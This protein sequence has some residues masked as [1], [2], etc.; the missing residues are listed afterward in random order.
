MSDPSNP[1]V[2]KRRRR[3]GSN[4]LGIT[5]EVADAAEE[6]RGSAK[7]TYKAFGLRRVNLAKQLELVATK[8]GVKLNDTT[9]Q[10]CARYSVLLTLIDGKPKAA[11]SWPASDIKQKTDELHK[12]TAELEALGKQLSE[13][14]AQRKEA[15]N[16]ASDQKNKADRAA[17]VMRDRKIRPYLTLGAPAVMVRWMYSIQAIDGI[18]EQS[19]PTGSTLVEKAEETQDSQ[20]KQLSQLDF[21]TG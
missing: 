11:S 15:A 16:L 19:L 9:S 5:G 8:I 21:F 20:E 2:S 14:L 7:A 3:G 10:A 13:T 6:A 12:D 18:P 1:R 4:R 17:T